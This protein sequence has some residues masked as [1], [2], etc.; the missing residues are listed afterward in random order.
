MVPTLEFHRDTS[1]EYGDRM[2]RLFDRLAEEGLLPG[3]EPTPGTE[4]GPVSPTSYAP[5]VLPSSGS[6]RPTGSSSPATETPTGMLSA[7]RSP[8][9]RW[10]PA[11]RAAVIINRDRT[12]ANLGNLPGADRDPGRRGPPR[13]LPVGLRSRHHRRVPRPRPNRVRRAAPGADPQYRPPSR[14]PRLRRGELPRRRVPGSRRDRVA[15][16]RR[17]RGRSHRLRHRH[18]SLRRAVDRH[19]RLSILQR[20][21]PRLSRC[22]RDGGCRRRARTG[23]QLGAQPPQPR[24]RSACSGKPCRA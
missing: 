3:D 4:E 20:N 8:S 13:G 11:R 2:E 24:L 21:Q 5:R 18:R 17:R 23:R 19:R 10:P 1:Y 16:V 15:D 14:Q 22:R 7:R 12:P 6:K 9:P